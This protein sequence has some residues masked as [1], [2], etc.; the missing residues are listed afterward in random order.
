M[1]LK[2][3]DWLRAPQAAP[4]VTDV[5]R[6]SLVADEQVKQVITRELVQETRDVP[7]MVRD[8]DV[9][10]VAPGVDVLK[11]HLNLKKKQFEDTQRVR[12][13][14][15]DLLQ[16]EARICYTLRYVPREYPLRRCAQSEISVG[17]V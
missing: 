10:T 8:R 15:V 11:Q 13:A 9:E 17:N 1:K 2:R 12:V 14:T 5:R 7:F 16:K 3:R 4:R 6:T